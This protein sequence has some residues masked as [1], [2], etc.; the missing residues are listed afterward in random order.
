MEIV[1]TGGYTQTQQD[2]K[3]VLHNHVTFD[4]RLDGAS[5]FAMDENPASEIQTQA[6]LL[7]IAATITKFGTLPMPVPLEVL[8]KLNINDIQALRNAHNK[9]MAEGV[10]EREVEFPSDSEVKLAF[11]YTDNGVTYTHVKFGVRLTGYDLVAADDAGYREGV[12]RREYFLIGRE[13]KSISTDDGQ[14]KLD[15]PFDLSLFEKLDG[16]DFVSMRIAATR[17]RGS[18]RSVP[19]TISSDTE[20]TSQGSGDATGARASLEPA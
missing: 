17:W 1:L 11:G 15:G 3:D 18:F 20:S 8:L 9:F 7:T 14:Y 4:K 2:K 5:L 13:L 10:G 12:M 16:E 6:M 19:N